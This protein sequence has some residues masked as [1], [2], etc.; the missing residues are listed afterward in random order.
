MNNDGI[1]DILIGANDKNSNKKGKKKFLIFFIVLLIILIGLFIAY[2]YFSK[3]TIT[4]KE[5]FMKHMASVN[6]KDILSNDVYKDISNRLLTENYKSNS[7]LNFSTNLKSEELEG[8][9]VSKLSLGLTTTKDSSNLKSYTECNLTYSGNEIFKM[10]LLSNKTGVAIFAD[11]IT[12]KYFG[13]HYDKFK[14]IFGI[15]YNPEIIN[16]L[17]NEK[18]IDLSDSDKNEYF[19]KYINLITADLGEECFSSQENVVIQKGSENVNVTAYTLTLTQPQLKTILTKGLQEL[20]NDDELL[21]KFI[22]DSKESN[23][24]NTNTVDNTNSIEDNTNNVDNDEQNEISENDTNPLD[25]LT[26]NI[27]STMTPVSEIDN[28]DDNSDKETSDESDI[29]SNLISI[30][31]GNKI[32]KTKDELKQAIDELI[33]YVDKLEGNGIIITVYATEENTEKIVITLPNE[34]TIDVEFL[35]NEND[36]KGI[37]LTYLYKGDNSIFKNNLN[38]EDV[39]IYSGED[40]INTNEEE[41]DDKINGFSIEVNK[42]QKEARTSFNIVLNFIE[43][44]AINQKISLNLN[45]NGTSN[46]SNYTNDIVV[47]FSTNESETQVV[48]DNDL[49]FGESSDIEDLTTDNCVYLDELDSNEQQAQIQQ[50]LLK[51]LEVYVN[52]KEEF[53]FL[54]TNVHSSTIDETKSISIDTARDALINKVSIM[55]REAIDREEEFTIH[56]LTDLNIDGYEVSTNVS[57]NEAIVVVNGYTFKIDSEFNLTDVE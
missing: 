50:F 20:K 51:I 47:T 10:N 4:Q 44:Q 19:K 53:K 39:L 27:T 17:Q 55:M 56:N 40:T 5:A 24:E 7:N 42:I 48:L 49:V 3:Q 52:K 28:S 31:L 12:D 54:D 18:K 6:I 29:V 16:N 1:E 26:P 22:T 8:I 57:E 14:D 2:R 36:E 9:D 43:D 38:N 34:N 35:K 25:N 23:T 21:E 32:N 45:T 11:E 46:A 41:I 30:L 37:K 13:I 15:D 33:T